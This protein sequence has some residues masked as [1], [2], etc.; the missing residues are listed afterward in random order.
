MCQSVLLLFR[1]AEQ[2]GT[3]PCI[4]DNMQELT[5]GTQMMYHRLHMLDAFLTAQHNSHGFQTLTGLEHNRII[6]INSSD[7]GR[8]T[9]AAA[10]TSRREL[11]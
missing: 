11:L 10:V 5:H 6:L 3:L 9:S 4:Q 7:C 8:L 2:I 1:E